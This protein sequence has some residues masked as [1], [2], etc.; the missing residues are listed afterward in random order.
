M[1]Y[2][3]DLGQNDNERGAATQVPNQIAP[4]PPQYFFVYT[5]ANGVNVFRGDDG[6]L[7][8]DDPNNIGQYTLYTPTQT[9]NAPGPT[10][11]PTPTPTPTPSAGTGLT[12]GLTVQTPEFNPPSYTPPPAFSYAD[13][14]A[15]SGDELNS[16]PLYKYSLKMQQDAIQRSAAARGILNTGGTIYDLLSNANDIATSA[17]GSLYNRNLGTYETNRRGA[18]DTYNMNYGT[19]YT[20]PYKYKYQGAS[21][22]FNSQVHASDLANSYG[23]AS[24]LFDFNKD[25]DAF[26][27]KYRLLNLL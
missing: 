24:R 14:V 10:P 16:D 27:R 13:F 6:Q 8:R 23:W 26:E 2:D 3:Q 7:Y 9:P 19:Q 18:V 4:K 21:D 15:P 1:V 11:P 20:D 17:Y 22:A 12:P 25:Q 5:D